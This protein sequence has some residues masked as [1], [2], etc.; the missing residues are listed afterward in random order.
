MHVIAAKAAAFGEAL[1]PEFK[2]Y[3]QQVLANART[4]AKALADGGLRIVSGHTQS[5]M[6][7]VDLSAKD[8]SGRQAEEALDRAH[9]TL[10]KNAIP[11][12]PRPPAE[13]SGIRIGTPAITSRGLKEDD[14]QEV[15]QLILRV[16]DNIGDASVEAEVAARVRKICARLPAYPSQ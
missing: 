4:M 15:A 5:H 13:A 9:I 8:V 14:V 12:D 6:F 10:N 3:Q 7:L 1:K 2:K 11:D 16:L